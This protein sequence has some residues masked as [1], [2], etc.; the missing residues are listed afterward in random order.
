MSGTP[1]VALPDHIGAIIAR[2]RSF[3]ECLTLCA[4]E[5]IGGK[6]IRRIGGEMQPLANPDRWAG[7]ALIVLDAPGGGEDD[8]VPF[9]TAYVDVLAYG[10]TGLEASKAARLAA[11]ALVPQSRRD[12]AFTAA[13]CRITDVKRVSG[14][15]P[16]YDK[17]VGAHVRVATYRLTKYEVPV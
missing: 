15:V 11:A 7:H 16:V 10:S 3:P 5:T 13:N 12:L 8:G 6:V 14:F 2:L 17:E 1:I 4:D 9:G